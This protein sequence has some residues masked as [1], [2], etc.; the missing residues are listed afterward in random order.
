MLV[1]DWKT[2]GERVHITR[3]RLQLSQAVL[4]ERVGISRN[5]ISMIE[6]GIA[7]PSYQIV[8]D[9]CAYLNIH[10]P[11]DQPKE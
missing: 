7:D 3:R 5:Y 11:P 8:V 4:A 1:I 2:F 6:R 9:L 10:Q